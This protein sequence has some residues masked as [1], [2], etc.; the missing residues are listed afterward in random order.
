[1]TPDRSEPTADAALVNDA[2]K[3]S[4]VSW[5]TVPGERPR[6]VW[7]VWGDG[8]AYVLH[9][10]DPQAEGTREQS[11][12]GL[13]DA[14]QVAVTARGRTGG[15]VVTWSAVVS[16]PEPGSAQWE[17]AV[18][19]LRTARLNEPDPGTAPQRW[20]HTAW[21]AQLRPTGELL[22]RPG[23]YEESSHAVPLVPAPATTRP[24]RPQPPH[25]TP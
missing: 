23:S 20:A 9:A 8:S 17:T 12:P 3:A 16:H 15:R 6:A 1:M 13:C 10:R 21:I 11:V 5:I 18:A 25:P 14:V 22:E 24:A 4:A 2:M 19:L 7:H